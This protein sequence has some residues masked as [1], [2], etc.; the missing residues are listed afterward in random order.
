M[1]GRTLR[2]AS[3][4]ALALPTAFATL[5]ALAPMV[6]AGT[7]GLTIT[8]RLGYGNM[9][10]LGDWM[11]VD[12]DVTNQGPAFDGS[13]QI[14]SA[15]SGFAKG[16]PPGS[17]S[18]VIY[19]AA[20]SLATGATK[21]FHTYVLQEQSGPITIQAVQAGHV[22]ATSTASSANTFGVLVGV[23]SDQQSTLSSL[24][25]AAPTGWSPGVVHLSSDL[26]DSAI[27]LR[28]FDMIA[29]DDFSTDTLTDSQRAALEDYV[30]NGGSLL[31][32]TG[33]SW[34]K[35][36]AGLPASILPMRIDASTVLAASTAL[37]GVSGLEIATGSAAPGARS[38]LSEDGHPLIV[39]KPA[40]RGLVTLATFDWNQ[41]A[42][43]AW[44][45]GP[46]L[47]R[48]VLVRTTLGGGALNN[49]NNPGGFVAS[50]SSRGSSVS[51]ALSNLPALAVPSF[52]VIGALLGLYVLVVGP[53]N[54]FV[55][56]AL[57][58][59]ALTWITV[60]TIVVVASAGAYGASVATKGRSVQ[61]NVV[62]IVHADPGSLRAYQEIY[63]GIIAPTRGDYRVGLSGPTAQI[64]PIDYFSGPVPGS[65]GN[66]TVE[67]AG[68]AVTLTGMTAFS[69]RGFAAER[70]TS[71]PHLNVQLQLTH[72]QLAGTVTNASTLSFTDGVV[73][74]G[75]SFQKFG[76]LGPGQ[77]ASF[78]FTPSAGSPF[79]GPPAFM[80]VYPNSF[81]GQ[82]GPPLAQPAEVER[83][84]ETKTAILSVLSSS[85]FK[86]MSWSA[87]PTVVAWTKQTFE[88][89]TVDGGRPSV[90]AQS[91][92]VEKHPVFQISAGS[93]P[94]GVVQGRIVDV[95]GSV[96]Q[97]GGPP[98]VI[99]QDSGSITYDFTPELAPGSRITS[100]SI[101][102]AN[103]FAGKGAPVPASTS[104]GAIKAQAWDWSRGAWI[105]VTF[106]QPG[107]TSIPDEAVN[108]S[109]GEVELKL[110]S[111]SAFTSG[112]LSLTGDVK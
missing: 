84:A 66:M 102:S 21:H 59:R 2:R 30:M 47:L 22:A 53:L 109:N 23:M 70:Y 10:K 83:E 58:R 14:E 105:D 76:A 35:T 48:Q 100:A 94:A 77:S 32:G 6:H 63:T 106:Q 51:Q 44:S 39:E 29:I 20:L 1:G 95:D 81:Y 93:L 62:S 40:G 78:S 54:Y 4:V 97:Q 37:K 73:L 80:N 46:V 38:W 42:V 71:A 89:V 45:G 75:N 7:S 24:A 90:Y 11:P 82:G 31:V 25:G 67:A 96:Q 68:N 111:D 92:V 85:G 19:Q 49:A 91:A 99:T 74:A 61:A 9:V 60:P 69:L 56:R 50:I 72:G 15:S 3:A 43:A 88:D 98:G 16:L 33:G 34:H 41:D 8:S 103:Q 5:L 65:G 107:T 87:T 79:T 26:P 55:L 101:D 27:V 28:A 36:L 86:G 112:L 57:N 12:V 18:A 108:A 64:A 52:W 17:G 13:L 110:S 104:G